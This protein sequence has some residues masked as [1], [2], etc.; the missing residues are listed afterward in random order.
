MLSV[1]VNESIPDGKFRTLL[2]KIPKKIL[3]S[4]FPNAIGQK[5]KFSNPPMSAM[6]AV[7][8]AVTAQTAKTCKI[9]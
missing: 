1:T 9:N 4:V 7:F 8:S 3:P 2:A 6:V 5:E